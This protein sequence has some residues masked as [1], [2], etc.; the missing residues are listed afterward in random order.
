M[1]LVR[2][3]ILHFKNYIQK[4]RGHSYTKE[5]NGGNWDASTLVDAIEFV[6][7]FLASILT[8]YSTVF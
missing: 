7:L 5:N 2:I 3:S 4:L 6:E 1:F 8:L